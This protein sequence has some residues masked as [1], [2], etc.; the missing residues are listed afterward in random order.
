MSLSSASSPN[1]RQTTHWETPRT[2]SP[3]SETLDTSRKAKSAQ[4]KAKPDGLPSRNGVIKIIMENTKIGFIKTDT[5]DDIFVMPSACVGFANIIPPV[6]T[7]V[8]FNISPD[9]K[10]GRDKAIL[11]GPDLTE[12]SRAPRKTKHHS[13]AKP[14][15]A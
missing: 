10:T 1:Y 5:D 4:E 13:A 9:A 15:G 11:V 14:I 7:R 8:T 12:Q 3:H 6:G 2:Y